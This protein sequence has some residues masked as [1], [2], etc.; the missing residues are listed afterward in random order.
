MVKK[1]NPKNVNINACSMRHFRVWNILI[2]S[3]NLQKTLQFALFVIVYLHISSVIMMM[4][5]RDLLKAYIYFSFD[6]T[7]VVHSGA[8]EWMC[9]SKKYCMW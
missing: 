4:F 3:C 9:S 1:W 5:T 7:V 2:F 8:H 6:C